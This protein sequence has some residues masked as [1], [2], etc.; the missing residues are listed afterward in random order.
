MLGRDR[1]KYHLELLSRL[2][3]KALCP[4]KE[5]CRLCQLCHSDKVT[6]HWWLLPGINGLRLT[7]DC[8]WIHSN[9]NAQGKNLYC[10]SAADGSPRVSIYWYCMILWHPFLFRGIQHLG[11][12]PPTFTLYLPAMFTI[13]CKAIL[14][15]IDYL[16]SGH[17]IVAAIFYH[18]ILH[19][20][21]YMWYNWGNMIIAGWLFGCCSGFWLLLWI[22][23]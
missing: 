5:H 11:V 1:M 20:G 22:F 7:S 23:F 21:W 9:G 6:W 18:C 2:Y 16:V 4:L 3:D 12:P 10:R 8:E 17:S 15:C 13:S 19:K 14:E